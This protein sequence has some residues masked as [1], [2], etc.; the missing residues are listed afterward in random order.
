MEVIVDFLEGDPDRPIITGCVYNASEVPPY[1]LPDYKTMSYVK[2][3]ST[4]GGEGFNEIRFDDKKGQEQVFIHAEK[5]KDVRIKHNRYE[6]VGNDSHFIVTHD[7]FEQVGGDQHQHV[8]GARNEKVDGTISRAAGSDIQEKAGQK[9]ALDAGTEIHLK[10]ALNLV[11]ETGVSL[12]LK[13]GSNFININAAG[14]FISGSVVM[15][16]SGGAAGSGA[17]SHP[18]APADPIEA[19]KATPGQEPAVPEARPRPEVVSYSSAAL[20]LQKAAQSGAP[21]C[22]ICARAAARQ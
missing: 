8:K 21:F 5:N 12:T 16:N 15:I 14:I 18:Q 2:S 1:K 7:Q 3:Y 4:T 11:L 9:Y 13:V 6:T 19:D 20:A 10:S 17:G 22:E